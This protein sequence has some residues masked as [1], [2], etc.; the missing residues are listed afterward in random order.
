[1]VFIIKGGI[2]GKNWRGFGLPFVKVSYEM[3]KQNPP[4]GRL[5]DVDVWMFWL[6]KQK[7]F[8]GELF[9]CG[10]RAPVKIR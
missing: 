6:E 4:W 1:M 7:V 2:L 3:D 10:L 5:P 8:V 9:M